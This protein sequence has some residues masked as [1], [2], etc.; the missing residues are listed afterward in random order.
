MDN[1][2]SILTRAAQVRAGSVNEEERS[3]EF[4]ISSEAVDSYDTVLTG[5]GWEFDRYN[6]NPVVTYNHHDHSPDPDMVIGTSE[7]RMEDGKVVAKLFF[8]SAED[9]PTAEKVF[10]K[11]KNRTLRGASVWFKPHEARFGNK[12]IPGEDPNVLYFT[13]QELVAWSVVTVP[14]NPDALARNAEC[15]RSFREGLAKPAEENTD[16]KNELDSFEARYMY[17]KNNG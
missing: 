15:V 4:V 13:R 12:D 14:S 10:R 5:A 3:A 9:N 2:K 6:E 17:N 1:D 8:E 11:V 16:S 7:V